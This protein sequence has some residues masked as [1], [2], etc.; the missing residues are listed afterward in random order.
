MMKVTTH[1]KNAI[2]FTSEKKN[3]Y[4]ALLIGPTQYTLAVRVCVCVC[5]CSFRYDASQIRD[6]EIQNS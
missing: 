4:T 2:D 5:V 1:K 3:R 6:G